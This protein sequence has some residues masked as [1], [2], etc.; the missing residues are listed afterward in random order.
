MQQKERYE[1]MVIGGGQAGLAVGY[2]LKRQGRSFVILDGNER[3]G[4][5]WRSRWDSLKLY[6]PASRDGLP[7]MPFPGA[8]D[9]VPDAGRDGRLPRGLRR[10]VRAAGAQR[11]RRRR[12]REEGGRYVASAGDRRF[13]ADNVVSRQAS[14]RSRTSRTFASELD[15]SITQL[16]SQRY[17]NLSQ[18]QDGPRPRRR[19]EPLGLRHRLRGGVEARGRPLG[20]GHRPDSRAR[21]RAGAADSSSARSSSSARTS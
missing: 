21:S 17:R 8:A 11:D 13:E 5:S 9:L 3:I 6:S 15:P 20:N 2:H 14:S 19:R 4:D 16:H 10:A 12:P 18:L 1:T 7:G